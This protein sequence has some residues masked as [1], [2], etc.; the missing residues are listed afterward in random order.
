M[1]QLVAHTLERGLADQLGHERLLGLVGELPVGVE[2]RALGHLRRDHVDQHLDLL[3]PHRRH[4]HHLGLRAQQLRDREQLLGDLLSAHLVDLG[5]HA[6]QRRLRRH[7][8]D[9]LHDPPVA[10]ADLLVGRDADR[11]HVDLGIGVAHQVVEPLA[12]QRARPV[13]ARGVDQDELRVLAVHDAADGVAGRLRARGGDR[14]LRTDQRIGQRRLAGVRPADETDETGTESGVRAPLS[15]PAPRRLPR[16]RRC[17]R[18]RPPC[19]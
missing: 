3:A 5:D 4:R 9:L 13:Q 10:R 8:L 16:R 12:E 6:E 11:D 18:P 2:R 14:D 19:R 17:R 1:R 15:H 7:L